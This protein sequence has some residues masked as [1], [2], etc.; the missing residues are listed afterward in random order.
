M[1]ICEPRSRFSLDTT[2]ASALIWDFQPPDY[3]EPISVVSNHPVWN[4]VIIAARDVEDRELGQ[5]GGGGQAEEE[6][7]T[8]GAADTGDRWSWIRV[9]PARLCTHEVDASRISPICLDNFTAFKP[10]RKRP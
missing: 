5:Q 1:F 8:P 7:S 2:S 3:E 4:S 6:T 10:P 9:G